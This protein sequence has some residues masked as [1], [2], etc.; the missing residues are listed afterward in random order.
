M[1]LLV[2]LLAHCGHLNTLLFS[3][4]LALFLIIYDPVY[5]FF[6]FLCFASWYIIYE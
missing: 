5:F 3:L 4:C 6:F 1:A 2:R